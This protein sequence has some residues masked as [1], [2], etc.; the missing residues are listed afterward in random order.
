M[1]GAKAVDATPLLTGAKIPAASSG[2]PKS[3]AARA[4]FSSKD[5]AASRVLHES[6][7]TDAESAGIP[8]EIM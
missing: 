2:D 8:Q 4:A 6:G 7:I 1:F 5:S 3:G